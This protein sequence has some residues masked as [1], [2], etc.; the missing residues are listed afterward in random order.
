MT[1]DEAKCYLHNPEDDKIYSAKEVEAYKMVMA[2]LDKLDDFKDEQRKEID[3]ILGKITAE[4]QTLPKTYPFVNHIDM[5]VKEKDVLR[6]ISK[7]KVEL[8]SVSDNNEEDA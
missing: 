3:K 7:Y 4:I 1:T 8:C 5:Y 2:A 6:I